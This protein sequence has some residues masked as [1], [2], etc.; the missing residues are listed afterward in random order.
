MN[1][2]LGNS[3]YFSLTEITECHEKRPTFHFTLPTS[4]APPA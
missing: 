4:G 3:Q 2:E 1:L